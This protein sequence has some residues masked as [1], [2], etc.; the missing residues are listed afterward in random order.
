MNEDRMVEWRWRL[1]VW[2]E[3]GK[4]QRVFH[5]NQPEML[6]I[7]IV[8]W[9]GLTECCKS[10]WLDDS[11]HMLILPG[12]MVLRTLTWGQRAILIRFVAMQ[13]FPSC[14]SPPTLSCGWLQVQL[15]QGRRAKKAV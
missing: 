9:L 12:L 11:A 8:L 14:S 3:L 7:P 1:S 5:S 4:S 6:E 13:Q 10:L 2:S 15:A